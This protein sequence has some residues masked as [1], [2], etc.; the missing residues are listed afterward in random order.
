MWGAP[1][2]GQWGLGSLQCLHGTRL[3]TSS[4]DF[5]G[6]QQW[7]RHLPKDGGNGEFGA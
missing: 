2:T 4:P 1:L 7:L 5:T 6:E 3:P